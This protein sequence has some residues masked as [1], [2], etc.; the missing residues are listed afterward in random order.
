MQNHFNYIEKLARGLFKDYVNLDNMV[1]FTS[2]KG[3]T[4]KMEPKGRNR[5]TL[6][7]GN[8]VIAEATAAVIR[9]KMLAKLRA[10]FNNLG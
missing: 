7:Q 1:A 4:Y 9:E 5:A 8:Q 10:D 6:K 3:I 2:V